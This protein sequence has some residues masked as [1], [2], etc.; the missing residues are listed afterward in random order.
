[1]L[2][3]ARTVR[4]PDTREMLRAF[5][6]SDSSYDGVFVTAVRT[7]GIFCRPSCPAKKPRPENVEFFTSPREALFAG[8]RPCKR[9]RPLEAT[10]RPVSWAARLLERLERDPTTRITA[11]ELRSMGIDPARARRYFQKTYGMTFQAF[12]RA[13]RL[14]DAFHY[15]RM[16]GTVQRA[17]M[18]SGYESESGFRAAFE[19]LFG[20][21]PAQAARGDAVSL[22]WIETPIGPMLAGATCQA[23]CLLEFTERRMLETQIATVRRLFRAPL[24]PGRNPVLEQL[25]RELEEYF[26]GRRRRFDVP[27]CCP[28]TPFQER[29][30]SALLEIPYGETV[31]YQE[32]ALRLGDA[33]ATRAVG[34]ANGMNR[35]AIVIP[36]HRVVNA[37][38]RLGGYGG[39]LWRKQYLLD[40]ERGDRL[41]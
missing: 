38:G 7:T 9:C 14:H 22:T 36:C 33:Q 37:D 3:L 8:Y 18:E 39:G 4:T 11:A 31:S 1:M 25:V 17:A 34:R 23:V 21:A 29:V 12:C 15:I 27:L 20:T 41:L 19:K 26:K 2:Q 35:I 32:L 30:W 40:L 13:R 24:L 28:G 5:L 10:G 6:A 16:G